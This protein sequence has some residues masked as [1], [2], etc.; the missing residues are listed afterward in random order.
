M[1]I[2]LVGKKTYSS[3]G[4]VKEIWFAAKNNIPVFGVYVDGAD[5]SVILPDGLSMSRTIDWNWSE[6]ADFVGRCM[7]EG[8]NK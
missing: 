2:V 5:E 8:K 6:I 3:T 1:L 4:V 7:R